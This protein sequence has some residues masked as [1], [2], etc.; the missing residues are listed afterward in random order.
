MEFMPSNVSDLIPRRRGRDTG[1]LV[2]T[3]LNIKL[4]M[5]QIF[6]ALSYI[7][8]N[9]ICHRDIKPN[10]LLFDSETGLM[11]ICDFGSAKQLIRGERNVSYICARYYRAPELL[12]G[13]TD[14][15]NM[16]GSLH[17]LL[18]GL[19]STTNSSLSPSRSLVDGHC[20]L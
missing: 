19:D 15:T 14:Y 9:G 4:V 12:F 13:A 1:S 5:Y 18:P 2:H 17:P 8:M 11:K 16:I 3:P 20:L 10:N 6:R 7:H